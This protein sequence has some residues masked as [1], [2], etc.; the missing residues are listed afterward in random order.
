SQTSKPRHEK[1]DGNPPPKEQRDEPNEA[2][3]QPSVDDVSGESRGGNGEELSEPVL[4]IPTRSTEEVFET[5][6]TFRVR[7]FLLKRDRIKRTL[8]GRRTRTRSKDRGGR[9]IRSMMLGKN[10]IAIDATIRA[11]APL[12]KKRCRSDSMVI[13]AV[14]IR[15]KQREKKT[16]H[17]VVF[18]VDGSG[19]MG[20]QKRMVESKGAVQSL[21]ADCYLK[22]DKVAMVVFRKDRAEVVLPPTSSVEL[23]SRALKAIPTGGKTPL[24]S[25]LLECYGLIQRYAKKAPETRFLLIIVTDGRAN[26]A[27]TDASPRQEAFRVAQLL[28]QLPKVDAIVVDTENKTSFLKADLALSLA[29]N[30]AADYYTMSDLKAEYLF[31]LAARDRPRV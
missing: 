4:N 31:D 26:H 2:P 13:H 19:S 28:R 6:E 18:A 11:A 25:G 9:Y 20:A 23:A 21:L 24:S 30:L 15:Y 14:D 5:G 17:L 27:I 16:G 22:R 29:Q 10:D 8:S 7:R 1:D 3:S 12:Q